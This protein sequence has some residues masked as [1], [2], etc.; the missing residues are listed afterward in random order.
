MLPDW[1]YHGPAKDRREVIRPLSQEWH[2]KI[3]EKYY[4]IDED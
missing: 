4:N 2:K 3:D 1:G